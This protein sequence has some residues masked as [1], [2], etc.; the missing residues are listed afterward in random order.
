MR[1]ADEAHVRQAFASNW[2]YLAARAR[3]ACE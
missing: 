1:G 2:L 3:A